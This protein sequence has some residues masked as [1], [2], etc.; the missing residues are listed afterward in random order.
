MAGSF[1]STLLQVAPLA[2]SSAAL[3]CSVSQ[4]VTMTA[5]LGHKV[6]PQARRELWY[7]FYVNYKNIVYVSAPSHLTTITTCLINYFSN[8]PSV[9]WLVCVAF[10]V[11][12][13]HP[14][15]KGIKLLNLTAAEWE[16]KTMP[17]T[18]AWFQD[19]VDIN[20]RRLLLVDLPGWLCVIATVVTALRTV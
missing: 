12:H 18:R 9:W 6:P 5:F 11:G 19:F 16:S 2:S 8:A 3:I 4:Q 13:A 1:A 20:Q 17:E 7:P 10:V 14:L 15:Q